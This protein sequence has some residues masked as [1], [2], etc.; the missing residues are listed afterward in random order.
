MH[1]QVGHSAFNGNRSFKRYFIR[2]SLLFHLNSSSLFFCT[3]YANT[4]VN[5]INILRAAFTPSDPKSPKKTVRSSCFL[6]FWDLHVQKLHI[7]RL[8]KLNLGFDLYKLLLGP[9][10]R[11]LSV[12]SI[13]HSSNE[14]TQVLISPD[15]SDPSM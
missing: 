5:F 7:N 1:D 10:R 11:Y 4:G 3:M 12:L 14:T 15:L 6:C 9:R 2:I 13:L 8:V